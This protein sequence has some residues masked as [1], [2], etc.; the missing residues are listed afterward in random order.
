MVGFRTLPLSFDVLDVVASRRPSQVPSG[1]RLG[2]HVV[3]NVKTQLEP[4]CLGR[5]VL[6]KRRLECYV[7]D[8]YGRRMSRHICSESER[9]RPSF[10]HK[11]VKNSM[12]HT[13]ALNCV[14][15]LEFAVPSVKHRSVME[16]PLHLWRNVQPL[17]RLADE[18]CNR[19]GKRQDEEP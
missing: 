2:I 17:R 15:R 9:R 18:R 6:D 19:L 7:I 16:A 1:L 14:D 4:Q 5:G 10:G 8:T 13:H 12:V 11:D 3:R